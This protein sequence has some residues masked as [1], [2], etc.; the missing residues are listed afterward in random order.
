M[1][2]WEKFLV[3]RFRSENEF[4]QTNNF[5]FNGGISVIYKKEEKVGCI[6]FQT[7]LRPFSHNID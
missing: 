5:F 6:H 4:L 3:I 1:T 7:F 2:K